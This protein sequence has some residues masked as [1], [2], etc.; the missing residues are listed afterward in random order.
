MQTEFKADVAT[1]LDVEP[2]AVSIT[3]SAGSVNVDVKVTVADAEAASTVAASA[4]AAKTDLVDP[5][6][7]GPCEV[8]GVEVGVPSE[9]GEEAIAKAEDDLDEATA[10]A[11]KVHTY[12][13][14]LKFSRYEPQ[15]PLS[16]VYLGC[17]V[18]EVG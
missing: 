2:V 3:A 7:F 10:A 17:T 12:S 1:K 15:R 5:D 4:E 11:D 18:D 13:T 9:V 8:S 14:Y 6:T 16:L